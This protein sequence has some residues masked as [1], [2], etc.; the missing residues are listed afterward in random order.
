M[1]HLLI[2]CLTVT[3]TLAGSLHRAK[4]DAVA[5]TFWAGTAKVDITPDEDV[6][7]DIL[8]K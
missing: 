1:R 2:V 7:V 4:A 8:G 3:L 5:E 6:A